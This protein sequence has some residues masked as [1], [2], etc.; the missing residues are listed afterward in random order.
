M[1]T[2]LLG[3]SIDRVG[4]WEALCAIERRIVHQKQTV[5]FTP[6]PIIISRALRDRNFSDILNRGDLNLADGV[7]ISVAARLAKIPPFPRVAGIDLAKDL[8]AYADR[9]GLRVFLLGGKPQIAERAAITLR[10]RFPHLRVCGVH[11]GYFEERETASICRQIRDSRADILFVCTGSPR[12]EAWID[13]N[14]SVLPTVKILIGLGGALVVWAGAV[15][16]A[17]HL[18]SMVGLEWLWR[19]LLEPRRLAGIPDIL[20]FLLAAAREGNDH[21]QHPCYT[22]R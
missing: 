1:R 17:P 13:A 20:L 21:K 6:N 4:R 2:K 12:Q 22:Q 9:A 10:R 5:V 3:V 15:T 19:M 7:G 14:R 8:L 11:H 16:R 18:I